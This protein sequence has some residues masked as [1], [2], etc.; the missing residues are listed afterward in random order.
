MNVSGGTLTG[1]SGGESNS[2]SATGNIVSISGGTVQSNVNGGFVASG[3]GKATGNIVNISGNADLSTATVAGGISSS[4]AFTGNTLNKN[5]DAAVHIARN[6]ASVNFGYS[7]NANIGELDSTPTGSA[8]SG[9]TVNT[10]ANNVSFDG[11]IS[12]SGSITKPARE[13]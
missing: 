2:G 5:S 13:R 4:D 9:V 6:F 7:G 3:S 11:V 8:L 1:V 12:G 10:N